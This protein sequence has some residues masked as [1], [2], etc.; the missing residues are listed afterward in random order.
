M[1]DLS[2]WT[3]ER[4]TELQAILTA[5]V[6]EC[7]LPRCRRWRRCARKGG[8]AACAGAV[9]HPVPDDLTLALRRHIAVKAKARMMA[10]WNDPATRAG[11][12]ARM[13]EQW[14]RLREGLPATEPEPGPPAP[15]PWTKRPRI[16]QL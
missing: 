13:A 2:G 7:P 10:R 11:M 4:E 15:P 6:R 3:E 5:R 16:R 8:P 1:E 14:R 12:E 9:R